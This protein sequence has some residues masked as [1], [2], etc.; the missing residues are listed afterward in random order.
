MKTPTGLA[1][2]AGAWSAAEQDK[3]RIKRITLQRGVKAS[4]L[5]RACACRFGI[6]CITCLSWDRL[7]RR[8]EARQAES[9]RR[10]ALGRRVVLGR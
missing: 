5:D 1:G 6:T 10:Q 7:I 9:L 2:L 8:H 3:F 4:V